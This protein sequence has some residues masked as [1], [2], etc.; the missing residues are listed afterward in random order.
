MPIL[1][2]RRENHQ[3]CMTCSSSSACRNQKLNSYLT[4][5]LALCVKT[6]SKRRRRR[7]KRKRRRRRAS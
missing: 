6:E 4:A 2:T 5:T 3:C 1:Q 7:E